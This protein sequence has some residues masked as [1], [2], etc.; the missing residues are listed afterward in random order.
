MSTSPE[1]TKI[2]MPDNSNNSNPLITPDRLKKYWTIIGADMICSIKRCM[3]YLEL[4]PEDDWTD[5]GYI[6]SDDKRYSKEQV[7]KFVN[8][9]DFSAMFETFLVV[10]DKVMEESEKYREMQTKRRKTEQDEVQRKRLPLLEITPQ[11]RKLYLRMMSNADLKQLY[12]KLHLTGKK[13]QLVDR[14]LEHEIANNYLK[15]T[16]PEM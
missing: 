6:N 16:N 10:S 13:E 2:T 3:R 7:R 9:T 8:S 1:E 14:I 12:P 15:T 11:T 4:K 5:F